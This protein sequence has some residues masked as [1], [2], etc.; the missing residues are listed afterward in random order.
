MYGSVALAPEANQNFLT[1]LQQKENE[2]KDRFIQRAYVD[3]SPEQLDMEAQK[4]LLELE[5]ML[6]PE[7]AL[8][9]NPTRDCPR[10][11]GFLPACVAF[12]AN[13]DWEHMLQAKFGQRDE[14]PDTFWRRRMPS[15]EQMKALRGINMTPDLQEMQARL[16]AMPPKD[17]EAVT[18]GEQEAE[19][20]FLMDA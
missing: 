18:L 4:I 20:T 19:F 2:N 13:A 11:C 9:P 7:L 12:D 6:N 5:D 8:Y 1:A 15:P 3:R 14:S 16:Q 17:A 10:M